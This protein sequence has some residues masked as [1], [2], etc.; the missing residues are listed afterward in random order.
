MTGV[1]FSTDSFLSNE[2]LKMASLVPKNKPLLNYADQAPA[3][4]KDFCQILVTHEQVLWV[5]TYQQVASS[6]V[7]SLLKNT[8]YRPPVRLD[9]HATRGRGHEMLI[10]L[11]LVVSFTK[12]LR[13]IQGLVLQRALDLA[14]T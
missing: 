5:Y 10:Y 2:S 7:N 1:D 13:L 4:Q 14:W 12:A 6:T 9:L 3:P 8:H 11:R